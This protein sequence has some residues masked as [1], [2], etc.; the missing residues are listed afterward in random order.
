MRVSVIKQRCTAVRH[1]WMFG[2]RWLCLFLCHAAIPL[3]CAVIDMAGVGPS[4]V[5]WNTPAPTTT[6]PFRL[7]VQNDGNVV[8]YT[9]ANRPFWATNTVGR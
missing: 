6:G 3:A 7:Q 2:L 4:N 8:I 5:Y 9:G 1:S